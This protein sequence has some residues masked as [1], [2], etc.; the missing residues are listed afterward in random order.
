MNAILS[1]LRT[2]L[3]FMMRQPIPVDLRPEMEEMQVMVKHY[4]AGVDHLKNAMRSFQAAREL[5]DKL[6]ESTKP[7]EG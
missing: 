6:H 2:L 4:Y 5:W 7:E 3:V 1:R